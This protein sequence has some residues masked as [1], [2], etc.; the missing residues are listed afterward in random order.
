MCFSKFIYYN[1]LPSKNAINI[2]LG[3]FT[4]YILSKCST[5]NDVLFEINNIN[6]INELVFGK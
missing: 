6:F 1:P 4:A 5:I 3:F 2:N